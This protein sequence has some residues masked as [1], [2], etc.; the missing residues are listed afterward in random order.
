[1]PLLAGIM[2]GLGLIGGILGQQESA[3]ANRKAQ[4][5]LNKQKK[6][7]E[8]WYRI[9]KNSD[10]TLRADVQA[11]INKQR[12]LLNER[13]K[14]AEKSAVVSGATDEAIAAQ[15]EASANAMANT[16]ADVA[17]AGAEH[18][19]RVEQQYLANKSK[20]EGEQINLDRE[21]AA[22]NSAA[23]GQIMSAGVNMIGQAAG[24]L[25]GGQ[26]QAAAGQNNVDP[27]T[28]EPAGDL[29]GGQ[30]QAAAGQNNVDPI[31]GEPIV[32]PTPAPRP[33]TQ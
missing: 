30:N 7:N 25:G 23:V 21:R 26:N 22:Q 28:G 19:D 3:A 20:L 9:Q 15:K 10:Y 14:A 13:Y 32:K 24:D 18:K 12:E 8:N 11:A 17:A 4:R 1:M 31:T 2:G 6:D 16:M 29:G 33:K 5:L 27:I